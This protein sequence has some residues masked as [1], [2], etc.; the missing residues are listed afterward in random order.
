[1][2]SGRGGGLRIRSLCSLLLPGIRKDRSI[3]ISWGGQALACSDTEVCEAS[4]EHLA[5]SFSKHLWVNTQ[6]CG[7]GRTTRL[8]VPLSTLKWRHWIQFWKWPMLSRL[9]QTCLNVP[10]LSIW[11]GDHLFVTIVSSIAYPSFQSDH[12]D[13]P[14]CPEA[15]TMLTLRASPL[16]P[17]LLYLLIHSGKFQLATNILILELMLTAQDP[18]GSHYVALLE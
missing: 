16:T 3:R 8:S 18:A 4:R 6:P 12:K 5:I 15:I 13:A 9:C 1:M 14:C 11:S 7:P 10:S 2:A 17:S